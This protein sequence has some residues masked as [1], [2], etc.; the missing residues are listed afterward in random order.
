MC[1]CVCVCGTSM[2]EKEEDISFLQRY[3]LIVFNIQLFSNKTVS[4]KLMQL[5]STTSYIYI[6]YFNGFI[7]TII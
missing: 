5:W 2:N 4:I 1:V 7:I 6:W 3:L